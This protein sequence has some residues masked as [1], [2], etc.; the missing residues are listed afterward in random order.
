MERV[1][2][3]ENYVRKSLLMAEDLYG[4]AKM[5]KDSELKK[6]LRYHIACSKKYIERAHCNELLKMR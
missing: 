4:L 2:V 6:E 3:T 5:G 1:E